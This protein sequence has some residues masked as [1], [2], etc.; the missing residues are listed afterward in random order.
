[1]R[2]VIPMSTTQLSDPPAGR[3]SYLV[4]QLADLS[5]QELDN[6]ERYWGARQGQLV[7]EGDP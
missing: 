5:D 3:H 6:Y 2:Q 1:M 4:D 7:A